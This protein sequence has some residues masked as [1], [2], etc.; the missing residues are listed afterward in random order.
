MMCPRRRCK[1][2]WR[3]TLIFVH[4]YIALLKQEGENQS[5]LQLLLSLTV[6]TPMG[7]ANPSLP[8]PNKTLDITNLA[9]RPR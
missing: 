4:I 9:K 5:F 3:H 8:G 6:R 1:C 7:R 2:A